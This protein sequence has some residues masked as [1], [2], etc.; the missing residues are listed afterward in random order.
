MAQKSPLKKAGKLQY[1][2]T[3][4]SF[5]ELHKKFVTDNPSSEE[6]KLSSEEGG[7]RK[8]GGGSDQ[9]VIRSLNEVH[10]EN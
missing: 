7:K 6:K 1:D 4:K 5:H 3:T 10:K 8:S 2:M 9:N